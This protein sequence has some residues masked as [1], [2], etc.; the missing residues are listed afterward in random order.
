M[1]IGSLKTVNRIKNNL[2]DKEAAKLISLCTYVADREEDD[3]DLF[4]LTKETRIRFCNPFT[5]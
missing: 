3:F 2:G 1:E 4:F 5:I